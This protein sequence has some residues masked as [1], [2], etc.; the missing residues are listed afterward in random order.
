MSNAPLVP[1]APDPL[2]TPAAPPSLLDGTRALFSGLGFI[3]R[4]PAMWPLA[5]VPV[6]VAGVVTAVVGGSVIAFVTPR[7]AAMVGPHAVLAVLA[8]ILAAVLSLIVAALIGAGVAQPLS[9]P[10]LNRIVR[11]VEADMGA[12]PRPETGFVED[13]GRALGSMLVG[14]TFGLPL[15]AILAVISFVFPPAAVITFPLKLIVL[16]LL[17]AWDLFDYPLSIHGMPL[18]QRIAL[19]V[20]HAKVMI[21]FGLGIALV[22]LIPCA[23]F[24]ALPIGVAG[25]ARLARRIELLERGAGS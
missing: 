25:A 12:P 17:F 18:G 5:L 7:V 24:F 2:A 15:L 8:Q 6:A 21:G 4:T 19:V 9:G 13:M 20:R 10:A 22:S 1:V 23:A 3:A 14:Y 11:R 16:A